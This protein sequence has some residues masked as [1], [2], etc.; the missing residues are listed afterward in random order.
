[1]PDQGLTGLRADGD[2][3]VPR[4]GGS[5]KDTI[6]DAIRG[7]SFAEWSTIVGAA[8]KFFNDR[9]SAGITE[10]GRDIFR[11]DRDRI[12]GMTDEA[13]N[14]LLGSVGADGSRTGGISSVDQDLSSVFADPSNV[15]NLSAAPDLGDDPR[16]DLGDD[17]RFFL[18][19]PPGLGD[20]PRFFRGG[21]D[22]DLDPGIF[23][24]SIPPLPAPTRVPSLGGA[25]PFLEDEEELLRRRQRGSKF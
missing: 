7:L 6:L 19:T 9:R 4:P 17:P 8:G 16:P 20:D 18:P 13:R 3:F 2:T 24:D 11:E 21:G 14:R 12:M 23:R 22:P 15:F 5:I 10:E 1:M 25:D